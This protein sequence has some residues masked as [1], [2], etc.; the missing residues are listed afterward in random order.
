MVQ[1]NDPRYAAAAGAVLLVALA[2]HLGSASAPSSAP[3][4]AVLACGVLGASVSGLWSK[5]RSETSTDNNARMFD[6]FSSKFAKPSR[7][8]TMDPDLFTM[9]RRPSSFGYSAA[10][11]EV[12]WALLQLRPFRRANRG[13]VSKVLAATEHFFK[14]FYAVLDDRSSVMPQEFEELQDIRRE[15]LNSM[16]TLLYAKP[17]TTLETQELRR[18]ID[19]I[20]WRTYRAM[21]TLHNKFGDGALRAETR[22]PPYAFDTRMSHDNRYG[23]H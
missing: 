22:G 12:V 11:P 23:V 7:L 19:I 10:H 3:F 13:T 17:H 20:K 16:T 1:V 14:R 5:A 9:R 21:K 2:L 8:A 18:A 4:Y 6:V 15:L